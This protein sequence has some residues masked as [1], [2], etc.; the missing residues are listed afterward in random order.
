MGVFDGGLRQSQI[1]TTWD[2][3][4]RP[5]L[6]NASIMT[7]YDHER[8]WFDEIAT[9]GKFPRGSLA[10]EVLFEDDHGEKYVWTPKWEEMQ[11]PYATAERIEELN[12]GGGAY[13]ENLKAL[14]RFSGPTI[15][16][17]AK[18]IDHHSSLSGIEKTFG[19]GV[20]RGGEHADL[21][22]VDQI[23]IEADFSGANFPRKYNLTDRWQYIRNRLLEL[24]QEDYQH[25]IDIIEILVHRNRHVDAEDRRRMIIDKLN[26]VL[27]YEN[28]EIGLDGKVRLIEAESED[29]DV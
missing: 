23:F 13:L 6:L 7:T 2:E 15:T 12:E 22:Q 4:S 8:L 14:Q 1:K 3:I 9:E 20:V 25:I 17:L 5:T 16:R 24:N 19:E 21:G 11:D 10:M 27:I 28:M 18:C 26:E 29:N